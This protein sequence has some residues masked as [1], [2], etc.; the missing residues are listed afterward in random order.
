MLRYVAKLARTEEH[1]KLY[2][3]DDIIPLRGERGVD[4]GP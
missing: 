4:P 3:F 2:L 1:F